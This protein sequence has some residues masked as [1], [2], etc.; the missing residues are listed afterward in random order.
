MERQEVLQRFKKV[1]EWYESRHRLTDIHYLEVKEK[2]NHIKNGSEYKIMDGTEKLKTMIAYVGGQIPT[3]NK[4]SNK[5][6]QLINKPGI[7]WDAAKATVKQFN[8]EVFGIDQRRS[9]IN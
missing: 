1:I 7:T 5:T 6:N 4:K 3:I 9:K 8:K 2:Y